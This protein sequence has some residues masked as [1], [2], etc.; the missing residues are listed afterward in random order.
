[1]GLRKDVKLIKQQLDELTAETMLKSR[2]Y[3]ELLEYLEKIKLDVKNA[4]LF[5]DEFGSYGVKID[6]SI[7]PIKIFFDSDGKLLKNE[8]F[9]A[10]NM[11]DLI[12]L[13]DMEKIAVVL[14]TATERNNNGS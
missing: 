7:E 3:D 13:A 1:M 10:I 8:R 5:T 9:Y 4:S 6:Y 11:L 12:S 2:K 14:N